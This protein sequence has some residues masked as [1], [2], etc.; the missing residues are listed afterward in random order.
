MKICREKEGGPL[1]VGGFGFIGV[2]QKNDFL[3][4]MKP[5]LN[6]ESDV[7]EDLI[8]RASVVVLST[9]MTGL[10]EVCCVAG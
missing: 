2:D 9:E 6:Q 10:L 3:V 7:N 8:P 5:F 4:V 1:G